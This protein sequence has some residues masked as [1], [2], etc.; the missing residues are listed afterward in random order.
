VAEEIRGELAK[1]LREEVTD[2]RIGLVTITHVDVAPDL[3]SA[4]VLWSRLVVEAA[5]E[6]GS[7][8]EA[9]P[10]VAAGL[11]SAAGFLRR[12]LAERLTIKRVPELRF[13]YDPSLSVGTRTLGLLREVSH[14]S[15]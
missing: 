11:A 15:D 12:R 5:P 13:V 9:D 6:D 8:P 1:L 4:R 10:A 7:L 3:R 2:P 14:G